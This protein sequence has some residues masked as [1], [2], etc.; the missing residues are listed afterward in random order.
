[1]N[2]TRTFGRWR[3]KPARISSSVFALLLTGS[4]LTWNAFAAEAPENLGPPKLDPRLQRFFAAKE[5]HG[6][7][8]AKELKL[9]VAP[10]IWD[11]FDAG[12]EG[13]WATVRKLWRNLSNRSGQYSR[14]VMDDRVRTVVWSPL[15]EAELGYECFEAMDIKFVEAF[16]RGTIDSIPRGSIYFGGTDSGRGV[17]TAFCK[18]HANA[19]PFF[20]LTQNALADGMYLNYLRATFGKKIFVPSDDDSQKAFDEY[21]ADAEERMQQGKLKPGEQISRKDGQ[22]Q[23]S[24][25]VAVMAINGTIAKKI[26]DGN[27]KREFYLEESLPLD[28]MYPHLLPHGLIMKVNRKPLSEIS[29]DVLQKDRDYWRKQTATFL[30]DWLTEETPLKVLCE[31]VDRV[32]L[33]RDLSDFKGDTL[34]VTA[35]RSYS[36]RRLYGKLRQAHASLYLWRMAHATTGKEKDAMKRAA[37]FAFKQTIALCPDESEHVR[38][39]VEL[40]RDEKRTEDARLVLETGL[41][42]NPGS[43]RLGKLAD[44]FESKAN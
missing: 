44:E 32:Y 15:L 25:Q 30:G 7:A 27:P 18:S 6:R 11:Y 19:D 4:A 43:R 34:Y 2:M 40:L 1:M 3:N 31:F 37:E 36:P 13:D 41:K 24:G 12:V 26:F 10:E 20:V 14:G 42:M 23:V 21:K 16:A 33:A 17:I 39:L 38:R 28:W 5:R 35:G 9:D 29:R 8:L 22:I